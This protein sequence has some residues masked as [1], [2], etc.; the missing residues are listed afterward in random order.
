MR[1]SARKLALLE[2]NVTQIKLDKIISSFRS[3]SNSQDHRR[4]RVGKDF[5]GGHGGQLWG[6]TTLLRPLPSWDCWFF[7]NKFLILSPESEWER[8]RGPS[9]YQIIRRCQSDFAAVLAVTWIITLPIL[10]VR[11]SIMKPQHQCR[12]HS[13]KSKE[14]LKCR[15]FPICGQNILRAF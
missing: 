15:K 14:Y 11:N 2:E 1:A 3:L 13:S 4:T 6:Q 8:T 12:S 10:W 5:K 9:W 7:R